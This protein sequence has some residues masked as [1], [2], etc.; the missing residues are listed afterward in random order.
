[1]QFSRE[2]F[3]IDVKIFKVS[4]NPLEN[5]RDVQVV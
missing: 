2:Y 4:Q 1:M 3:N 5:S